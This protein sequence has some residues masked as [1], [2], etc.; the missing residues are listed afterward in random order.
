MRSLLKLAMLAC[1][2][3]LIASLSIRSAGVALLVGLIGWLAASWLF[4][5]PATRRRLRLFLPL[6]VAAILAQAA[7]MSWV[8]F[9][10]FVEW[11]IGG[12]PRSYLSQLGVKSGNYPELGP[13]SLADV[14]VRVAKNLTEHTVGYLTLLT[15]LGYVNPTWSSPLMIGPLILLLVGLA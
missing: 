10:E 13:A 1:A 5:R 4:D 12:Y 14:P 8:A 9:H 3:A 2:L 15:R 6:V 7:W 11:P